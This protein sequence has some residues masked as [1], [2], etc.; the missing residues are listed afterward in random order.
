MHH[1][2]HGNVVILFV[3]H[4]HQI[5]HKIANNDVRFFL[6]DDL[7]KPL[8]RAEQFAAQKPVKIQKRIFRFRVQ[9]DKSD[10]RVQRHADALFF[11]CV[12]HHRHVE[13]DTV[14]R[15]DELPQKLCVQN[16]SVLDDHDFHK[17]NPES[18]V[19][20]TAVISYVLE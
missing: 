13:P 19:K 6:R 16:V 15:I 7:F 11:I 1:Y 3:Q 10:A 18:A 2:D 9:I 8:N 5:N 17:T 12:A 20:K 4:I 14:Q